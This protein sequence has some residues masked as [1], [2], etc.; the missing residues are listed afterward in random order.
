MR[1]PEDD[2]SSTFP[3][4]LN[5]SMGTTTQEHLRQFSSG[6]IHTA[7]PNILHDQFGAPANDFQVNLT[8]M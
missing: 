1:E 2:L 8:V 7:P 5:G 6:A 3:S 4:T